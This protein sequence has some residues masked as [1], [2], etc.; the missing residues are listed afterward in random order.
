MTTTAATETILDAVHELTSAARL[1][2]DSSV[3]VAALESTFTAI[4][5]I[6]RAQVELV[7]QLRAA[8]ITWQTIGDQFG[9]TRQAAQQRFGSL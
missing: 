4:A 5:A 2:R 3:P 6:E 1:A 8:G 7:E 9:I